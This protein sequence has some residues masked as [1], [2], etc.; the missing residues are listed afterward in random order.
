MSNIIELFGKGVDSEQD[1]ASIVAGQQC[2]FLGKRCYKVRKS[3][4]EISIG[5]C[6]VMYGKDPSPVLICPTRLLQ[7]NQIFIDGKYPLIAGNLL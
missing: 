7:R 1:W 4:P 2:P 3:N 5:T 6:S